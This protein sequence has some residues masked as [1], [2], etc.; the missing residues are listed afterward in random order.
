M[1]DFASAAMMRLIQAGLA[2]QGVVNP[3]AP[4]GAGAHVALP[5]KR[6]GVER[7]LSAHGP[8]AL[9]RIGDALSDVREA[10]LLAALET[11]RSPHKMIERWRRMEAY[12]HSKHR[13]VVGETDANS[14]TLRHISIKPESPPRLSEGL[15]IFFRRARLL[16]PVDRR[17]WRAGP[18]G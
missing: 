3:A 5:T 14:I 10:P 18:S 6:E 17:L 2:K 4:S 1:E 13:T 9:L 11:A 7:I 16:D 12:A 8:L 15:L